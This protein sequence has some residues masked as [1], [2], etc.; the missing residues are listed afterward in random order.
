VHEDYF[1]AIYGSWVSGKYQLKRL[2]I[3][4]SSLFKGGK[5]THLGAG[6]DANILTSD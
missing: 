6:I 5:D 2:Q 4:Q 3:I 1:F